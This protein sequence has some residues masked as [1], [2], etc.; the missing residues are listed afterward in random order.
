MVA[1][2]CTASQTVAG[3]VGGLVSGQVAD[4]AGCRR[5]T[6]RRR[7]WCVRWCVLYV[8]V[9]ARVREQDQLPESESKGTA[10]AQISVAAA[11]CK[12]GRYYCLL[13]CSLRHRT[14]QAPPACLCLSM[15]ARTLLGG[16]ELKG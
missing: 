7:R 4:L 15:R 13:H 5:L 16:H 10:A 2:G 9:A 8:H 1:S 11:V 6:L 12:G 3:D 14:G